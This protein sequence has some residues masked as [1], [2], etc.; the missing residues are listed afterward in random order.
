MPESLESSTIKIFVISILLY[1]SKANFNIIQVFSFGYKEL[2]TIYIKKISFL[3]LKLP[4]TTEIAHI[5]S[6]SSIGAISVAQ[7][8]ERAPLSREV[9]G[10][11]PE[12]TRSVCPAP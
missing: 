12:S 9:P 2:Q 10:L 11:N 7:W 1:N 4:L 6:E 3:I 5:L 8:L